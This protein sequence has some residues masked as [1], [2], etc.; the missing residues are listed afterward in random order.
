[1]IKPT[2][3]RDQRFLIRM[4]NK[5]NRHDLKMINVAEKINISASYI[6]EV[7][8]GKKP[9]SDNAQSLIADAVKELTE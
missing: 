8:R 9:L 7:R 2:L 5:L 1:M 6:S 3:S 4:E